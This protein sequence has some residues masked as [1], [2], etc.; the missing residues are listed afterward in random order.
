M[1]A[2]ERLVGVLDKSHLR[3]LQKE[4]YLCMAKCCDTANTPADL[5]KWWVMLVH[6]LGSV[7][8]HGAL[9]L[10]PSCW[11]AH[12]VL[13]PSVLLQ[14][15]TVRAEGTH[16]RANCSGVIER[17]PRQTAE[18]R[19]TVPGQGPGVAAAKAVGQGCC[20]GPRCVSQLR[21]RLCTRVRATSSQAASKHYRKAETA[22]VVAEATPGAALPEHCGTMSFSTAKF[23]NS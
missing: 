17:L 5:Q 6:Q 20:Q 12:L 13:C 4:S 9:F 2:M 16:G 19:A 14:R 21:G 3:L 8:A 1:Q 15:H 7:N 10:N 23:I 22:E 18:V 11:S